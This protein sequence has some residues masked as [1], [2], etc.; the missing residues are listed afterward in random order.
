MLKKFVNFIF[1]F[2]QLV[3]IAT[4][5]LI[6]VNVYVPAAVSPYIKY[7][8]AIIFAF[9]PIGIFSAIIC[10]V[11]SFF[12]NDINSQIVNLSY[13]YVVIYLIGLYV[14]SLNKKQVN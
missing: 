5:Y 6:A 1:Y 2:V 14:T 13:L 4:I 11:L 3:I 8:I 7:P 9:V 10:I 12:Y